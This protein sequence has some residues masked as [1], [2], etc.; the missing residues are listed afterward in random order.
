MRVLPGIDSW[1]KM[2]IKNAIDLNSD[3]P[4]PNPPRKVR[5]A[6]LLSAALALLGTGAGCGAPGAVASRPEQG[7]W[8]APAG[9][10]DRAHIEAVYHSRCGACHRPVRP[11]SEPPDRLQAELLRHRK[12]ARLTD[13]EWAGLGAFLVAR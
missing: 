7:S 9:Q 5:S 10:A 1:L 2:N 6:L 4:M 12:R 8:S 11:G 3:A 13:Q